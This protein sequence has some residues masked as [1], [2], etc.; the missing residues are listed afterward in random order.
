MAN[1]AV[2]SRPDQ[3]HFVDQSRQ[4]PYIRSIE[5]DWPFFMLKEVMRMTAGLKQMCSDIL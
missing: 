3:N 1:K 2:I 4:F 5:N